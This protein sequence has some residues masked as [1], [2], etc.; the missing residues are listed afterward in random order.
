MFGGQDYLLSVYFRAKDE[1]S[2]VFKAVDHEAQSLAKT[3]GPT[4]LV[5]GATA[6]V[7]AL[8]LVGSKL[9][10]LGEEM[11]QTVKLSRQFGTTT[12]EVQRLAYVARNLDTDLTSLARPIIEL[13]RRL[14]TLGDQ[15]HALGINA[16]ELADKTPLV[17]FERIA[18]GFEGIS[19]QGEKARIAFDLF[20][21]QGK[22]ML[23]VM[24][25]GADEI[26]K[27]GRAA[28]V[29][30]KETVENVVEFDH[31]IGNVEAKLKAWT[32]G[33]LAA[34][35]MAALKAFREAWEG[36]Q[37]GGWTGRSGKM[38]QPEETFTGF[39]DAATRGAGADEAA[40][41]T[42]RA[43]SFEEF[44]KII[45]GMDAAKN[46][47]GIESLF[48]IRG[49]RGGPS[50]AD[51]MKKD[52]DALAKSMHVYAAEIADTTTPAQRELAEQMHYTDVIAAQLSTTMVDDLFAAA[53]DTA[54]AL[55]RALVEHRNFAQAMKKIWSDLVTSIVAELN[56]LITRQII[57]AALKAFLSGGDV[58][59]AIA[60]ASTAGSNIIGATSG[61][62]TEMA[63]SLAYGGGRR[64]MR[65]GTV[66]INAST[67]FGGR[68][69]QLAFAH[70]IAQAMRAAGVA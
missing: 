37:T 39:M 53:D 56:R 33:T 2:G 50:A 4:G 30:S 61:A 20:G 8:A 69:E 60:A 65:T 11:G 42:E 38:G 40:A 63:P 6:A 27:L 48:E 35:P 31:A 19:S 18:R 16:D 41:F 70:G 1:M 26:E 55:A 22:E 51:E 45:E 15:L 43:K 25:A 24:A 29:I 3:L 64:S 5:L 14:P 59:G 44:Q 13:Q 17:V 52:V 58:P 7:G 46:K 62:P 10:E 34:P 28:P 57:A 32:W 23:G 67:L 21:R 66:V 36:F 68:S 54:T 49:K 12:D 9:K 47:K